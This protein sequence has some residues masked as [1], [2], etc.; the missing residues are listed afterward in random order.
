MSLEGGAA[1][2]I[3]EWAKEH[4][5]D[6]LVMGTHGFG[7]LRRMLVGSVAMKV[8]HDADCPV[9]MQGAKQTAAAPFDG[10][11]NIICCI[12]LTEELAPL[13]RF[14]K[15]TSEAAGGQERLLH[16]IPEQDVLPYRYFDADFHPELT[17]MAAF[18]IS[19]KQQEAGTDFLL[20]IIK[21]HISKDAAELAVGQKADLMIIG[22]GKTP[23]MFGSLRTNA[24][25]II[26]EAP[27]P[28]LSY[29]MD[30]LAKEFRPAVKEG[31]TAAPWARVTCLV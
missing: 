14:A 3:A 8:L 7:A 9:W 10:V 21:G 4:A 22:R 1:W 11:K 5:S 6:L 2:H 13:L 27:C 23:G 25:D 17:E 15:Q 31:A 20:S 30:C 19:R 24:A 12:E 28:V 18:E 29:S 26:R 16:V